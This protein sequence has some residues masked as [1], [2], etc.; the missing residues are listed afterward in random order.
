MRV[1]NTK[2]TIGGSLESALKGEYK[3]E[4]KEVLTEGWELTKKGKPIILLGLLLVFIISSTVFAFIFELL[5]T[6]DLSEISQ[7]TR[8]VIDISVT[9]LLAPFM[10]AMIMIGISN[11]IRAVSRYSFLFHFI[12]KTLILSVASILVSAV[13]QLG[14]IFL[15]V[16]GVY[17]VIATTYTI[18][19]ILDKGFTPVRAMFTSIKVVHHQWFEFAKIFA[20]FFFLGLLCLATFGVALIWVAPYYYNVKGILYREVFGIEVKVSPIGVNDLKSDNIFHA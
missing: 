6:Y 12:P 5:G 3:F 17:L 15:I 13:V 2:F 11:S 18:P 9:I 1:E 4:T 14:F 20:F 8:M 10:A 7:G 16:P 19:L